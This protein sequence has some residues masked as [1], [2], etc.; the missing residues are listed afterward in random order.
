M[1]L[2]RY[3]SAITGLSRRDV[4][5]AL[6]RGRVRV[7]GASVHDAAQ[8]LDEHSARVELDGRLLEY[9]RHMHVMLNKPAGVLTATEDRTQPTVLDLL[10]EQLRVRGITP[11]GRLDKDTTGLLL[12][13]TDG[14]L[15]HRLISPRHHVDKVYMARVDGALDES[16]VRAFAQGMVLSDFTA[17]PAELAIVRPD[18]ARVTLGEG[19]YH[20]VKRMFAARGKPVLELK[21]VRMG[22]IALDERLAPGESRELSADERRELYRC[23]GMDEAD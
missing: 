20:Q 22:A 23:A 14:Q 6:A 13:T 2:D 12:L 3:I 9:R 5:A 18:L 19:K 7:D 8:Q 15:A 10:P 1:R 16:D 11:V 21:R 4:K 17:L